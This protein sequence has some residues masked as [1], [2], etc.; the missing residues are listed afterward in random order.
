MKVPDSVHEDANK[1]VIRERLYKA[2]EPFYH[3]E[4]HMYTRDADIA[5]RTALNRSYHELTE[6]TRDLWDYEN[7]FTPSKTKVEVNF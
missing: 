6:D 4:A 7:Q 1:Q 2:Y 3:S 5:V